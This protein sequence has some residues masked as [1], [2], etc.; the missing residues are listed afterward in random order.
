M[1]AKKLISFFCFSIF[2]KAPDFAILFSAVC[3][4]R[5]TMPSL[6]FSVWEAPFTSM[7]ITVRLLNTSKSP[8][9]VVKLY[10]SA[11]LTGW[12]ICSFAITSNEACKLSSLLTFPT[13]VGYGKEEEENT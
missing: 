11:S 2:W 10:S 3:F 8:F 4:I 5:V 7:I 12:Q 13:I 1:D 6:A 9:V